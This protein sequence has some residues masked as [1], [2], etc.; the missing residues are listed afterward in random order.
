MPPGLFG[1]TTID[2]PDCM[3]KTNT[4]GTA[5]ATGVVVALEPVSKMAADITDDRALGAIL[6]LIRSPRQRCS[7]A[8]TRRSS[9][10]SLPH[11]SYGV[12]PRRPHA[13][14][15]LSGLLPIPDLR[16]RCSLLG[17]SDH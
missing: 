17:Y 7:P 1:S 14:Q 9:S 16:C 13:E 10:S 4:R 12:K 5:G 3:E 6:R 15:M 8:P 11:V 2:C